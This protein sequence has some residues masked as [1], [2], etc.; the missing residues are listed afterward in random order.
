MGALAYSTFLTGSLDDVA[1][2]I[3]VDRRDRVSVVGVTDSPDF[4]MVGSM[5]LAADPGDTSGDGIVP[6]LPSDDGYI[7]RLDFHAT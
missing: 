4:P 3:T 5:L 6:D 2:G 1:Q 7:V